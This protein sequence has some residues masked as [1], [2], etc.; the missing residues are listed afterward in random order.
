MGK[1][2]KKNHAYF[3]AL[4]NTFEVTFTRLYNMQT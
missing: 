1:G 3:V 4:N 2:K